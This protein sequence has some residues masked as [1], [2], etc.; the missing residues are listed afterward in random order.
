[1]LVGEYL[2]RLKGYSKIVLPAHRREHTWQTLMMVLDER[3]DRVA[4][5]QEL[6]RDGV[7]AGPGSVAAHLGT[8]FQPHSSLAVS[9]KLHHYGLALPLHAGLNLDQV[10]KTVASLCRSLDQCKP[11]GT[12]P[13]DSSPCPTR[14]SS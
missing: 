8:H 4:I 2:E 13:Q 11:H 10:N 6:A 5:M 9:E 14:Q 7:E 1:L 12:L 3:V